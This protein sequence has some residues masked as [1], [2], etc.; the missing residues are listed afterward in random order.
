MESVDSV[1][2]RTELDSLERK[3]RFDAALAALRQDLPGE[4]PSQAMTAMQLILAIVPE[5]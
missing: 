2:K 3:A 4:R 1:F 5:L